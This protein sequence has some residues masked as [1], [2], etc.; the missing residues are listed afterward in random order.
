VNILVTGANGLLGRA[1]T[2][3]CN[4]L[5]DQVTAL[6]H[7]DLDISDG[8]EVDRLVQQVRPDA[9]VNCAAWTDVDGCESDPEKA[10]RINE[11]G[12]ANLSQ[13]S[14]QVAALFVTV[15]TDYVFDGT[16]SGFYTQRDNPNPQSVYAA[17]KLAGERRAQQLHARTV[18]VRTGYVFGPGG[19]NFLSKAVPLAKSGQKLTAISDCYGTPTYSVDLAE[20]LRELVKLDLPG[21]FHVV[22]SGA[23]TSFEEFTRMALELAGIS[24]D[25][26]QGV[27]VSSLGRPAARP[28]NSRLKCLLSEAIGLVS[29]PEWDTALRRFVAK[30]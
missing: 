10:Y 6:A 18:V 17:S 5:G 25:C 29:M 22:N 12:V 8:P 26:L 27:P 28:Q 3:K 9:V 23:G 20:R 19:T 16:K 24:G 2:Q 4:L 13:A 14:R 15:S 11:G 30:M 1:F 7:Q 21:V